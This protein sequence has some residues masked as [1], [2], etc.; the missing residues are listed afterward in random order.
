VPYL[1]R[2]PSTFL[3]PSNRHFVRFLT[4][5]TVRI[6]HLCL[7]VYYVFSRLNVRVITQPIPIYSRWILIVMERRVVLHDINATVCTNTV[8]T[9]TIGTHVL[10][11]IAVVPDRRV[12]DKI[13]YE[14]RFEFSYYLNI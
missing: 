5:N 7:Y 1:N 4:S 9:H 10:S 13:V 2:P 6:I 14:I 8:S 11:Y 12:A 3:A